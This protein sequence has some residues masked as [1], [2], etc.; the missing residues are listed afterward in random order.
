[1]TWTE[2]S[3][4]LQLFGFFYVVNLLQEVEVLQPGGGGR[5]S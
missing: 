2:T 1:M 5:S 4:A 3:G